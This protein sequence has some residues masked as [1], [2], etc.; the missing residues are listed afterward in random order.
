MRK[1]GMV[2]ARISVAAGLVAIAAAAQAAE[3]TGP[4]YQVTARAILSE[5][6]E[7]RSVD[8]RPGT[9][10]RI[11][12]TVAAHLVGAGFPEADVRILSH[13]P[14]YGALVARYRGD[15][16]SGKKPILLMA[17]IDVVDALRADWSLDPFTLTEK[18][19]YFY[20]RGTG[21]NKGGAAALVTT[22]MRLKAEGFVPTRDLILVLSA[23]EE[24]EGDSIQWL[25]N[26][27]RQLVD[28]EYALNADG[29]GGGRRDGVDRA[30]SAQASEKIYMTV[31]ARIRNKGGHSS[32]PEKDNAI[33]RLSAALTR[34]AAHVFPAR[35]NEV[36]RGYFSVLSGIIGGAQG[37][38][39]AAATTGEMD[40][41]ATKAAIA[42]L[43][44]DNYYNALLR[45]TCVATRL[46]AG[47]AENALP[48]L[49]E[50]TI[51]CRV[52][53]NQDPQEVYATLLDVL[54]DPG[55]EL[56]WVYQPVLSPPSPLRSDVMGAVRKAVDV[57]SPGLAIIPTMS[58]GASDG[59]FVRNAGI[60]VYGVAGLF[61]DI[62]DNRAHGRDE[63]IGVADF[64][65][66][67][68]HWHVLL[69]E[70]A[71]G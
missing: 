46:H 29:G 54:D 25:M 21:D 1:P 7:V 47:H 70:L 48:Q 16:S 68:E 17:H 23:D 18:D 51:N 32:R 56:A 50:A 62:D 61:G 31:A 64:Y 71:G 10:T 26:E 37:A 4:D 34:L 5:M 42:R 33:Y 45:T 66:A 38:D 39:M 8:G 41:P 2:V 60:P 12:R 27:N 43:A 52:L 30:Y 58:T 55:I 3:H 6:V 63:R 69:R 20:G 28:A 65:A 49:A 24:T 19:G 14:D 22:F 44:Q 59:L 57:N 11:A 9:T 40:D 67:L 35:L 53:P 13:H 36:T 15:G